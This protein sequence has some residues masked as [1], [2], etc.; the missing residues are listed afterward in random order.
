MITSTVAQENLDC[1]CEWKILKTSY[2]FGI[3][4][5]IICNDGAYKRLLDSPSE[6]CSID[7]SNL[8]GWDGSYLSPYPGRL[9]KMPNAL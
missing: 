4:M 8:L 2:S 6:F 5:E 1:P 7:S 9:D 3:W